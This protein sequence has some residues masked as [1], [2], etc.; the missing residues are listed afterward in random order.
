MAFMI[1]KKSKIPYRW[2]VVW[3]GEG[4]DIES[5]NY[6]LL[7][8]HLKNQELA[9]GKEHRCSVV[10]KHQERGVPSNKKNLYHKLEKCQDCFSFLE[11]FESCFLAKIWCI[12]HD[13]LISAGDEKKQIV[14]EEGMGLSEQ[15]IGQKG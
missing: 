12:D 5:I 2:F 1:R 13:G 8:F 4:Q 7:N 10:I 15:V 14:V 6:R 9:N 11:H 3:Q